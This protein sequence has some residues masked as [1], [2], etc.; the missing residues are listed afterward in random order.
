MDAI[1]NRSKLPLL[2]CER[3]AGNAADIRTVNAKILQFAAGHAAKFGN[4][5]TELAP[6]V[7]GAC[8]VHNNPLSGE[9]LTS[10]TLLVPASFRWL[11][12]RHFNRFKT[13]TIPH[14]THA[15]DALL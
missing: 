12:Y 15:P 4:G 11:R 7:E 9:L 5:Q 3:C 6:V 14:V 1:E 8:Y 2:A 13:V 10:A